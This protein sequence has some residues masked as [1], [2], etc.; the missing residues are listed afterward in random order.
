MSGIVDT[1]RMMEIGLDPNAIL[2]TA[3]LFMRDRGETTL[4]PPG[5]EPVVRHLTMVVGVAF[6]KLCVI[7]DAEGFLKDELWECD[8]II[9]PYKKH[10]GYKVKGHRADQILTSGGMDARAFEEEI[11]L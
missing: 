1:A 2:T 6:D 11:P 9:R 8:V 7:E 5:G 4:H 10:A 3:K